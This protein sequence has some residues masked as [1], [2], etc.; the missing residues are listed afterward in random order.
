MPGVSKSLPCPT[1]LD[2][3][4]QISIKTYHNRLTREADVR[5]QPPSIKSDTGGLPTKGNAT[6]LGKFCFRKYSCV[7]NKSNIYAIA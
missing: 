1:T 2:V 5:I 3:R 6:L 7:L 4:G